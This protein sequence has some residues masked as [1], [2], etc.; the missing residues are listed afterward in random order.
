[1]KIGNNYLQNKWKSEI[2]L[3]VNQKPKPREKEERQI[4]ENIRF[5]Y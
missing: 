2:E 4:Y 1:M 5:D 3:R